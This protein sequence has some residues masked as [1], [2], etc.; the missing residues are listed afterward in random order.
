MDLIN[1]IFQQQRVFFAS[2]KTKDL[3]FRFENLSKLQDLIQSNSQ[4]IIQAIRKDF[5]KPEHEIISSEIGVVLDEIKLFQNKLR[6]WT[7]PISRKTPLP[8]LFA[9]SQ[10][11]LEPR[12]VSLIIAPWNYPFQLCFAPLVGAVASGQTII[13]KPSE[14]SENTT[15]C[16]QNLI[17]KYFSED[18]I[19]VIGGGIP[20]T[21]QLLKLPFDHIF[22]TGST[23]VGR[24]VQRAAAEHLTPTVLELGGKSPAIV[25]A[26]ADLEL[27][28][29]KLTWGKFFNAGQT[30]VAPDYVYVHE[31]VHDKF[32]DL[33]KQHIEKF[34]GSSP[35]GSSSFARIINL[36]HFDRLVI[37]ID[38]KKV[39]CGGQLNRESKYIAPTLMAGVSW[40]DPVMKQEIFGPLLPILKYTNLNEL[41]VFLRS[42]P[43][44][45]S[46]YFFSSSLNEQSDFVHQ[47]TFGG[48]VINDCVIHVGNSHIPFG[49]VGSSGMGNYH[50]YESLLAFSHQKSVMTKHS[51]MD[52]D[53]RYPPYTEN[54][55]RW[56][57]RLFGLKS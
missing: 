3:E 52:L 33:M 19:A 49:G 53:L 21:T 5:A 47:L 32:L 44:P 56:I 38:Q 54:K 40:D 8:F 39:I 25:T 55:I 2:G 29:R 12:G 37:L 42:Q 34:Y 16:I 1:R 17:S 22:F 11:C 24:I 20:E 18:Y 50:G 35:E 43:K 51:M 7:K 30:C 28:A 6:S 23:D 13:L 41:Y 36:R 14:L 27:A 46:A 57:K 45:L 9:Q 10:I 31:S 48:G 15:K 4:E 26:E